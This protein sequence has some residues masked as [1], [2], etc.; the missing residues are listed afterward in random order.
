M[1]FTYDLTTDIGKIRLE[2]G[3]ASS[4]T[5]EGIKP[6]G[7]NFTD[8]ELQT[9]LDAA[10]TWPRAAVRALRVA[11]TMYAKRA[12]IV[13]VGDVSEN[14][15]AVAQALRDQAEMLEAQIDAD[16]NLQDSTMTSA[17]LDLS[18]SF[19]SVSTTGV[20]S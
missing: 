19:Y 13:R 7:D 1:S 20:V 11:A 5:G 15:R 12:T 8:E 6:S 3:D 9:F 4:V 2:I 17:T 16:G 10:G 18:G 14:M